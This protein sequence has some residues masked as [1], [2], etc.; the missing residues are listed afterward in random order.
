MDLRLHLRYLSLPRVKGWTE[1]AALRRMSPMGVE[2]EILIDLTGLPHRSAIEIY[3]HLHNQ[4][5]GLPFNLALSPGMTVRDGAGSTHAAF[6][7]D[8]TPATLWHASGDGERWLEFDLGQAHGITRCV[9]RHAGTAGL[10]ALLNTRA[11]TLQAR[12]D[13]AP[14][15]TIHAVTD[16]TEQA[17]DLEPAPARHWRVKVEHP[18]ADGTARIADVDLFGTRIDAGGD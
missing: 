14:L 17:T 2:L 10:H 7:T 13:G 9:I 8:G 18:G 12:L 6:A 15:T 5:H 1:D 11:F 16:N 4:A 3:G